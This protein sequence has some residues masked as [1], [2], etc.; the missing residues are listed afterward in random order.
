MKSEPI[1]EDEMPLLK[2]EMPLLE[3][4]D[5]VQSD[6]I[7]RCSFCQ[8]EIKSLYKLHLHEQLHTGQ[9]IYTC[10]IC[11]NNLNGWPNRYNHR[12]RYHADT[13]PIQCSNCF[14]RFLSQILL[15]Q[16]SCNM[17]EICHISC[18]NIPQLDQHY[19]EM[20]RE[21]IHIHLPKHQCTIC[22]IPF[23]SIRGLLLHGVYAHGKSY[24]KFCKIC[25]LRFSCAL[26]M[27]LHVKKCHVKKYVCGDCGKKTLNLKEHA[28]LHQEHYTIPCKQCKCK[29]QTQAD[30]LYHISQKHTIKQE[31]P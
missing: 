8:Y 14:E 11:K 20:H 25:N 2:D 15:E 12:R 19:F 23:T 16:H 4:M 30:L 7:H 5:D 31:I 22:K 1:L 28:K 24:K 18:K 9:M 13:H 10:P 26:D 29:L 21:K 17:C 3:A 6:I 27:K